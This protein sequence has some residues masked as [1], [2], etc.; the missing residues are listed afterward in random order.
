MAKTKKNTAFLVKKRINETNIIQEIRV[1]L[2]NC[3]RFRVYELLEGVK[4]CRLSI[5]AGNDLL[6]TIY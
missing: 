2:E 3:T 5:N 1:L 4:H 6:A